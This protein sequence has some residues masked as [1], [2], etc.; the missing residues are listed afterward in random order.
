MKIAVFS[1]KTYDRTFLTAAN[2]TAGHDLVFFEPRLTTQTAPL[3]KGFPVV[4]EFVN[5]QLDARVLL[6]L[7][8]EGVK[9]I[10]LRS[11]GFNHVDLQAAEQLGLVVVARAGL[12]AACGRRTHAGVDPRAGP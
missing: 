6:V 7:A 10:A 1:T 3:A 9:L 5:D 12:L 2:R 11:A 4:R 8:K